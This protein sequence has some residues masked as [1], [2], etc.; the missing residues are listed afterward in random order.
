L[1]TCSDGLLVVHDEAEVARS[2][3]G[4]AS[5]GDHRDELVAHVNECHRRAGAAAQLELEETS[6]P[7]QGFLDVTDLERDVV[8]PNEAHGW[9]AYSITERRGRRAGGIRMA[10]MP[11]GAVERRP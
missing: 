3:W 8:D 7:R 2:I 4:L 10:R 9:P 1:Q 6:V 11:P 5:P